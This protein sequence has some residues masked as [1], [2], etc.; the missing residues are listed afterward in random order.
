MVYCDTELKANY[1]A[2][3]DAVNNG[4]IDEELVSEAVMRI[5]TYKD[6]E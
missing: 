1:Q 4:T 5:L 2:V 3:L 6:Y